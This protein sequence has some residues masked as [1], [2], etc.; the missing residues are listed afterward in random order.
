MIVIL[1]FV[2]IPM[3]IMKADSGDNFAILK[4]MRV[5]EMIQRKD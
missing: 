1:F 3:E 5:Y 2:S 4:D